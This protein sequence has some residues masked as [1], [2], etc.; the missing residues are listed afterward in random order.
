MSNHKAVLL[1]QGTR[2]LPPDEY[3]AL[4]SSLQVRHQ[5]LLDGML[6]TGMRG[7]EFWRFINHQEWFDHDRGVIHL[8]SSAQLKKKTKQKERDVYLST[9]GLQVIE[10]VFDRQI[11]KISRISWREDLIRGA[12]KAKLPIH[13]ITPKM[14]RKT[15]ESW[16]V[17]SYPSMTIQIALS[18]GHSD[19]TALKHY[20]NISFSSSEKEEM[21]K[22][23]T[24]FCGVP[25]G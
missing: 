9:W 8:P 16:L 2:I 24:G 21:K 7:E 4:R 17:A 5:I 3:R 13:G 18:Q 6:F 1:K 22:Y 25:I 23:V 11:K 20:L 14:T 10:R 15:W 12:K 19:L